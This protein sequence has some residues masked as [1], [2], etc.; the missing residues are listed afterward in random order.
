MATK[1][2]YPVDY[3]DGRNRPVQLPVKTHTVKI[4]LK[5]L[6]FDLAWVTNVLFIDAQKLPLTIR[7]NVFFIYLFSS[8][9]FFTDMDRAT[10]WH[11]ITKPLPIFLLLLCNAAKGINPPQFWPGYKPKRC[12]VLRW[13]I[14]KHP[15]TLT[16]SFTCWYFSLAAFQT[17]RL[18]NQTFR[19]WMRFQ[20]AFVSTSTGY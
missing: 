13:H 4:Q 9:P 17:S 11:C 15:F 8:S 2:F 10:L 3:R 7:T 5:A 18:P 12:H 20:S 1:L 6:S 16:L 14:H 19:P